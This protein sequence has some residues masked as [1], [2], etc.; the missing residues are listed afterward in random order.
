MRGKCGLS[1]RFCVVFL[2]F[3]LGAG[4]EKQGKNEDGKSRRD[5]VKKGG[6]RWAPSFCG[7]LQET[8]VT[9]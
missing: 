9:G 7:A 8:E 2:V 4:V 1:A 6:G 3:Y 5:V